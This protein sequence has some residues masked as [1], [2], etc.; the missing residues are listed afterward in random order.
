[1]QPIPRLQCS[2]LC[3]FTDWFRRAIDESTTA[4]SST[5][6]EVLPVLSAGNSA[7]S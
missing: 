3:A 1:M 6:A 2:H 4:D 5:C 7:E